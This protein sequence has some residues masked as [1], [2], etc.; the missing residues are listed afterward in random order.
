M[1]KLFVTLICCIP[2]LAQAE[3]WFE[4]EVILFKRTYDD[5]QGETFPQNLSDL[6]YPNAHENLRKFLQPEVTPF[7]QGQDCFPTDANTAKQA[8]AKSETQTSVGNLSEPL[9]EQSDTSQTTS[10]CPAPESVD[11]INEW[12]ESNTPSQRILQ[13]N[14]VPKRINA[15]ARSDQKETYLLNQSQ[16]R[17]GGIYKKLQWRKDI[18]PMLHVGWRFK[19]VP[20]RETRAI[21]LFAGKNFA[22]DYYVNG[23]SRNMQE[24]ASVNEDDYETSVN[25]STWQYLL[26]HQLALLDQNQPVKLPL[27]LENHVESSPPII[28]DSLWEMDGYIRIHLSH[29]LYVNAGFDL[30]EEEELS[31]Q[32]KI[33]TLVLTE[34]ELSQQEVTKH[35]KALKKIRFSQFRRVITKEIHYF[36]HPKMGMILQLRRFNH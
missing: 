9:D 21:H 14:Q 20:R 5:V 33:P 18:H 13:L 34:G 6:D 16:L 25:Q 1:K 2:L 8:Q 17:L 4:A 35:T 30:R 15:P 29:Y 32:E 24:A 31:V 10:P 3:R 22:N 26:K 36:D 28:T 11:D 19:G 7:V 23:Q 27:P 12:L